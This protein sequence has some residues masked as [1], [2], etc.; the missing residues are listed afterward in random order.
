MRKTKFNRK[1]KKKGGSKDVKFSMESFVKAAKIK[2]QLLKLLE[3]KIYGSKELSCNKLYHYLY[4]IDLIC[5][6]S[7]NEILKKMKIDIEKKINESKCKVRNIIPKGILPKIRNSEL[8]NMDITNNKANNDEINMEQTGGSELNDEEKNHF[9][10]NATR[11]GEELMSS[12]TN[13]LNNFFNTKNIDDTIKQEQEK[14]GGEKPEPEKIQ[15]E[16]FGLVLKGGKCKSKSKRKRAKR[17]L[18]NLK[19]KRN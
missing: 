1:T 8:M 14:V 6:T 13:K 12:L 4:I 15:D 16:S 10:K 11:T 19:R 2:A 3:S 17:K 9:W 7:D 5:E 18:T